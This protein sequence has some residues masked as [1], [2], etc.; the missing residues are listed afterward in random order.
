MAEVGI[1]LLVVGLVF[2]LTG[3]TVAFYHMLRRRMDD[4]IAGRTI[5]L[6]GIGIILIV[7]GIPFILI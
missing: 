6:T 4:R 3:S 7:L 2:S 1:L 5:T